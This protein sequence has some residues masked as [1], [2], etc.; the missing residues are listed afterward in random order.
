MDT[1][2]TSLKEDEMRKPVLFFNHIK[3][4]GCMLC[5]IA[6]SLKHFDVAS[7]EKSF[8]HIVTNSIVGTSMAFL[9]PECKCSVCDDCVKICN[10]EALKIVPVESLGEFLKRR[11]PEWLAAPIL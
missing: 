3:C 8:I 6:C 11:Q 7:R 2:L 4:S 1:N 10:M 9:S 5:S